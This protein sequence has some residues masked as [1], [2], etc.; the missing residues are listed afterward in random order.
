ME[1]I[2]AINERDI[3]RQRYPLANSTVSK[4]LLN[5]RST[6]RYATLNHC[7]LR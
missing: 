2:K 5:G 7:S 4:A 6:F 1:T 3:I